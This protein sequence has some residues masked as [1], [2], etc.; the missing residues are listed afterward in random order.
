[1]RTNMQQQLL[2]C[3]HRLPKQLRRLFMPLEI[4]VSHLESYCGASHLTFLFWSCYA[5]LID[6]FWAGR[7]TIPSQ[8]S[9]LHDH[10]SLG[11]HTYLEPSISGGA[12]LSKL[13]WIFFPLFLYFLCSYTSAPSNLHVQEKSLD[14][15]KQI[16]YIT[17]RNFL[18]HKNPNFKTSKHINRTL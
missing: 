14:S 15:L 13:V 8:F 18:S 5:Y 1:M 10:C 2:T 17:H 9:L 11:K 12:W 16:K 3:L 6:F 4:V 7:Y